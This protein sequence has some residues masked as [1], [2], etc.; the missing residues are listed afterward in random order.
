MIVTRPSRHQGDTDGTGVE[1]CPSLEPLIF[2]TDNNAIRDTEMHLQTKGR[3]DS[4]N[5]QPATY[6]AGAV[7]AERSIPPITAHAIPSP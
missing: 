6:F 5:A 3:R 7:S 1:V 4:D 2:G